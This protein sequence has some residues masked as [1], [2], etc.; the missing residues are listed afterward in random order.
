MI[1]III[2]II[3]VQMNIFMDVNNKAAEPPKIFN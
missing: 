2:I 1:K 3:T